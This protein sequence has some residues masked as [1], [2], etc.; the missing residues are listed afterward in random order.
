VPEP[1]WLD[2]L[3]VHLNDPRVGIVAPRI[4]AAEGATALARFDADRSP[5]DL[6][7]VEA[8]VAPGSR[9]SY[10]PTTALLARREL[11]EE[12]GG[13]DEGL[14]LGEDV[15]LVWRAIEAGHTVR[16]EPRAVA[17]HPTRSDLRS[18]VRQR[19]SYGTSAAPLDDRHPGSVAPLSMSGWTA[20]AWALAA[21]GHPVLGAGV[22]AGATAMLPRQLTMLK[23]PW[24]ESWELAGKGQLAAWR[25]VSSAL[26]RTWW[27]VAL[28]AALASKRARRALAL[29]AVVP[30]LI[31]WADGDR[32]LDPVRYVGLRLLDDAAYGAGVWTG[33]IRDR[34]FRALVPTL[35]SWPGRGPVTTTIAP[36]GTEQPA[37]SA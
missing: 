25:P 13:F 3:L 22:A 18:W 23:D 10:V 28:G 35:R 11:L 1:G 37:A 7:T 31:D 4:R 20:G 21:L 16:Y 26:T 8:R 34:S 6:G 2:R 24:R 19:Y 12:L 15:D 32:H 33:C 36:S 29:A 9:V 17:V 14:P 5:L 30:P 27:P